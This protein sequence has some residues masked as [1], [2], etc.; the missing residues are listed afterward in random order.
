MWLALQRELADKGLEPPAV[1]VLDRDGQALP[2]LRAVCEL[3]AEHDLVL[4]TGHLGR[5]EIFVVCETALGAGV[6]RVVVTHPEFP[7]QNLPLGDQ[8]ALAARGCYLERCWTTPF[9][10]KYPWPQMVANIR[11]TGV[12]RAVI[13]SDLGQPHNAPVEDGLALMADALNAAGFSQTDIV[14]MIVTN[15]R[16]IGGPPGSSARENL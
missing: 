14:T 9:T 10:G 16:E 7:Q 15:S 8:Q 2:A 13:S 12:E 5:D 3:I 6:R 11:A 4:A 1:E